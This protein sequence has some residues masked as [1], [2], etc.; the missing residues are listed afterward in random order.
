MSLFPKHFRNGP[1]L[2][3]S[4]EA[5][6]S[7]P[8]LP[9]M[10]PVPHQHSRTSPLQSNVSASACHFQ[11]CAPDRDTSPLLLLPASHIVILSS[12]PSPRGWHEKGVSFP[13][14]S[15]VLEAGKLDLSFLFLL[16]SLLSLPR[17]TLLSPSL[18]D[19]HDKEGR[20]QNALLTRSCK[21]RGLKIYLLEYTVFIASLFTVATSKGP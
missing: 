18:W 12:L 11:I 10:V 2:H 17:L 20:N 19:C 7:R 8:G 21:L 9:G 6:G 14:L 5:Q 13:F 4:S 16:R 15:R 3:M 1:A